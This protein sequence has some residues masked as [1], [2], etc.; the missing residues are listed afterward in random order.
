MKKIL[1]AVFFLSISAIGFYCYKNIYLKNNLST[2]N[3]EKQKANID[4]YYIYGTKLNIIGS[5]EKTNQDF[6]NIDLILV[7]ETNKNII[8]YKLNYQKENK[9][10]KF[11]ISNEINNGIKLEDIPKGNYKIYIRCRDNN[12]KKNT[13]KYYIL[14][15]KTPYPKTNYY[16][17]SNISNKITISEKDNTTFLKV[18]K[19]KE[20][21][22]DIVINPARG[23]SDTGTTGNGYVESTLIMEFSNNLKEE[24]EKYGI[25]VKLTRTKNSLKPNEYFN[26]YNEHG[27]AVI[28]HEVHAKYVFSFHTNSSSSNLTNGISIFTA[29]NINY[30]FATKLV[31]NITTKTTMKASTNTPYRVDYG[32]YTHN[33]T[34]EEIEENMKEYDAKGYQ[35]YD[36]SENANYLYMIREPGGM[37]TGAYVDNRNEEVGENPYYNSNVGAESYVIYLGYLTNQNDIQMLTEKQ[38][39]YIK[40][41]AET[42]REQLNF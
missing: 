15:N 4:K 29:S 21:V 3:V 13:D 10:V 31:E 20:D 6:K 24:L 32:I 39:D 41:L 37:I 22:Y 40:V 2:I 17:L 34:K 7:N 23:G 11:N 19:N 9:T 25:K 42:I 16:T 27:R 30:D 12:N 14:E 8:N 5:L 26:E 36:I 18:E 35:R 33:F 1:I 38:Q 28:S